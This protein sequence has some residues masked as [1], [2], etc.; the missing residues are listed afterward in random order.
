ML[1][2]TKKQVRSIKKARLGMKYYIASA[3]SGVTEGD[4][5]FDTAEEAI[6]TRDKWEMEDVAD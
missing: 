6:A 5:T 1:S 4:E 3:M 2:E